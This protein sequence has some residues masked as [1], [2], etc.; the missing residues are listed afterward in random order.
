MRK[1][2]VL[3][4]LCFVA[5][6]MQAKTDSLKIDLSGMWRFQLDPMGFGKTPGS[7]LYL[8]KLVETI[9]LPGSTDQGGKGIKNKVIIYHFTPI[10]LKNKRYLK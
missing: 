2:V 1:T 4:L 9:V 3:L 6:L 10:L 7:E 8:D 5:Y